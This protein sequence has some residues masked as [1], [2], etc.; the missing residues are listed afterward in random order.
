MCESLTKAKENK[1]IK[2]TFM[3]NLNHIK[4]MI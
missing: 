2:V 1:L 4:F 3:R